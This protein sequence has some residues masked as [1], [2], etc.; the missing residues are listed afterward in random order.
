M[1]LP[2]EEIAKLHRFPDA[3]ELGLDALDT[4]FCA[5][6]KD[7]PGAF[8]AL[9]D[10]G[11]IVFNDETPVFDKGAVRAYE[12]DLQRAYDSV[13]KRR[14][15]KPVRKMRFG[16]LGLKLPEICLSNP[17]PVMQKVSA[18]SDIFPS[19][20]ARALI[21]DLRYAAKLALEDASVNPAKLRVGF[22]GA[23]ALSLSMFIAAFAGAYLGMGLAVNE[24]IDR[25]KTEFRQETNYALNR[26]EDQIRS[27]VDNAA[28]TYGFFPTGHSVTG[29]G[30]PVKHRSPPPHTD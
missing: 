6:F 2:L 12:R 30:A 23:A 9:V 15:R 25:A 27:A 17:M 1:V 16:T 24:G 10:G 29:G 21:Y 4:E 5:Y 18:E 22:A 8:F 7:R 19:E 13:M 3:D 11:Q 26:A 28:R 20:Y 14:S